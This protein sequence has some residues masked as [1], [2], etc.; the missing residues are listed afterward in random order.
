MSVDVDR[1]AIAR[2]GLSVADVQDV[3]AIAV[4]GREAGQVFEGDRRFDLVV[5]L[6][7]AIPR[8]TSH[9][10][11]NLPI[12][13]RTSDGEHER[14]AGPTAH[15]RV[16]SR[17]VPLERGRA[18]SSVAEGPEPDQPRERQAPH[19]RAGE[20]ARPRHRLVRR[21]GAGAHRARGAS[22]RRARWLDWGGQFENLVAAQ[23]AAR[24][25]RAGLLRR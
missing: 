2:Y 4:G 3:V 25:R 24:G 16:G 18:T 5:R 6:P 22:C 17:F 23:R 7:D 14:G 13:L 8:A 19:R 20:R 10:L 9:A 21:R 1:A 15:V 12:P 11:E